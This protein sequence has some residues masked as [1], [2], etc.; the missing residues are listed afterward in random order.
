MEWNWTPLTDAQ[1]QTYRDLCPD[2]EY[3]V[4][5]LDSE[6]PGVSPKL[7][8][9]CPLVIFAAS[10]DSYG[11]VFY[12]ANMYRPDPNDKRGNAVD[13]QS[14]GFVVDSQ[15]PLNS[16]ILSQ[17]GDWHLRT[18]RPPEADWTS[19]LEGQYAAYADLEIVPTENS[20]SISTLD[21][22]SQSSAFSALVRKLSDSIADCRPSSDGDCDTSPQQQ[23]TSD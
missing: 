1:M 9:K 5:Q 4:L 7:T 16:G 11:R 19:I 22:A 8:D 21:S 17:H 15:A 13:Q 23:P 6:L 3:R 20:G 18:T 10:G 2:N 12:M 14:F